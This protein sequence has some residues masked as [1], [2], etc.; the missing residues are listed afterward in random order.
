MSELHPTYSSAAERRLHAES[1]YVVLGLT[2]PTTRQQIEELQREVADRYRRLAQIH[3]PDAATDK[4]TATTNFTLLQKAYKSMENVTE[5]EIGEQ[6]I[7]LVFGSQTDG[8]TEKMK[9]TAWPLVV[10]VS[11]VVSRARFID[12]EAVACHACQE[13][14]MK[15][16]ALDDHY[17][18]IPVPCE[19]CGGE[20]ALALV[21]AQM[22]D[23]LTK[24]FGTQRSLKPHW[25]TG[26]S[27]KEFSAPRPEERQIALPDS[28]SKDLRGVIERYVLSKPDLAVR[29]FVSAMCSSLVAL[30]NQAIQFSSSLSTQRKSFN[31]PEAAERILED[32]AIG[33]AFL[34]NRKGR[35]HVQ[36]MVEEQL[37]SKLAATGGTFRRKNEERYAEVSAANKF[38]ARGFFSTEN[39][40]SQVHEQ[41]YIS[42]GVEDNLSLA[43]KDAGERGTYGDCVTIA[44]IVEESEK[45]LKHAESMGIDMSTCRKCLMDGGFKHMISKGSVQQIG[46]H[47][48][49]ILV[50]A[51]QRLHPEAGT[52]QFSIP[53]KFFEHFKEYFTTQIADK[54]DRHIVVLR[55]DTV[56]ELCSA[57]RDAFP[58]FP[59]AEKACRKA[60]VSMCSITDFSHLVPLPSQFQH[61]EEDTFQQSIWAVFPNGKS[62]DR[63]HRIENAG[64]AFMEATMFHGGNAA[65]GEGRVRSEDADLSDPKVVVAMSESALHDLARDVTSVLEWH[66]LVLELGAEEMASIINRLC[67]SSSVQTRA[68]ACNL[69]LLYVS[70]DDFFAKVDVRPDDL[71]MEDSRLYKQL[72]GKGCKSIET[73]EYLDPQVIRY[74]CGYTQI[75][76]TSHKT[77]KDFF[78]FL[79]EQTEFSDASHIEIWHPHWGGVNEKETLR[80]IEICMQENRDVSELLHAL[81]H[82]AYKLGV[83]GWDKL[84]LEAYFHDGKEDTKYVQELSKVAPSY[85]LAH[86]SATV[87]SVLLQ[88]D[89]NTN[90]VVDALSE[91]VELPEY[92]QAFLDAPTSTFIHP[93]ENAFFD[94]PPEWGEITRFVG[95]IRHRQ[96]EVVVTFRE[97]FGKKTILQFEPDFSKASEETLFVTIFNK[98]ALKEDDLPFITKFTEFPHPFL[99]C[100]KENA[101]R[102]TRAIQQRL[103]TKCLTPTDAAEVAISLMGEAARKKNDQV[104]SLAMARML[105]SNKKLPRQYQF[106]IPS[107]DANPNLKS[108]LIQKLDACGVSELKDFL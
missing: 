72:T 62:L 49:A 45:I 103:L 92:T 93:T 102:S 18:P 53:E 14:G 77:L 96:A 71:F 10:A 16:V 19:E 87:M 42:E 22:R 90:D 108:E 107:L 26:T 9:A 20:G 94:A 80:R 59:Y 48:L 21:V 55:S 95:A 31:L 97:K 86:A 4:G 65:E 75:L 106:L 52:A 67:R 57:A 105:E 63:F 88:Y 37:W 54:G 61:R 38:P 5:E 73:L 46:F 11:D 56:R 29:P 50:A 85:E 13:R 44:Q 68:L 1:P 24:A 30:V 82:F 64:A 101:K 76:S 79:S 89:A 32:C 58:D 74:L 104:Q 8:W 43:I 40:E 23:A 27:D 3:H 6:G 41:A 66:A 78:V 99:S 39:G 69:Y 70:T 83:K 34:E 36:E 7:R 81:N 91:E 98:R 12:G 47:E 17:L 51:F 2:H 33:A 84:F 25:S 35:H 15:F 60:L 28:L 100:L